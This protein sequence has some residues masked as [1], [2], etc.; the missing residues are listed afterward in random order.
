MRKLWVVAAVAA[1]GVTAAAVQANTIGTFGDATGDLVVH[2]NTGG[3][4]PVNQAYITTAN[5]VFNFNEDLAFPFPGYGADHF[6]QAIPDQF[7]FALSTLAASYNGTNPYPGATTALHA[8]PND[9]SAGT[10]SQSVDW[11]I[12]DPT[13]QNATSLRTGNSIFRGGDGDPLNGSSIQWSQNLSHSGSIFTLDISGSLDTDGKIWW[14]NSPG[15]NLDG[16]SN[17]SAFPWSLVIGTNK[18]YFHGTLSYDSST[19]TDPLA[20]VYHGTIAFD[21]QPAA[22]PLPSSAWAGLAL[23]GILGAAGGIRRFRSARA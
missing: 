14:A 1:L 20:D 16:T 23:L 12:T 4:T 2:Y 19:D 17:L 21:L 9:T 5:S 18:I 10:Q 3:E 15:S 6:F 8:N 22:V 13:Y 7:Q 11:A